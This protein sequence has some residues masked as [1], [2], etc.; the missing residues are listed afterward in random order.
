MIKKISFLLDAFENE[1]AS[2]GWKLISA[3][4]W[5]SILAAFGFICLFMLY[6]FNPA[7]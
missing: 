3:F 2:K 7:V 5:L 4:I 1:T 6:V